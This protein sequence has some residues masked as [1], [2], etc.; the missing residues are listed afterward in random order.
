MLSLVGPAVKIH[1]GHVHLVGEVAFP[2]AMGSHHL[3]RGLATGG[4]KPETVGH[5]RQSALMKEAG[6]LCGTT[7]R[8]VEMSGER[9]GGSTPAPLFD[10][11]KVFQS[12]LEAH[13]KAELSPLADSSKSG[14]GERTGDEEHHRYDDEDDGHGE[15]HCR[16][17]RNPATLVHERM[18]RC[19]VI[20]ACKSVRL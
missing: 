17:C 7:G 19:R 15:V 12:V 18:N 13:T 5:A 16:R 11:M 3:P 6:E 14:A 4:G 20:G 8:D 2:Q 1:D 10:A 9:L